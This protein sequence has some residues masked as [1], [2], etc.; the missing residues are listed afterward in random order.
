[1]RVYECMRFR[2]AERFQ[3]LAAKQKSDTV[4]GMNFDEVKF[5]IYFVLNYFAKYVSS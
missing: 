2:F 4:S 3:K 5:S 1:M